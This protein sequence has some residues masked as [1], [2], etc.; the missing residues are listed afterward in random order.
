M[1]HLT[2]RITT[3]PAAQADAL[4]KLRILLR[5]AVDLGW[6]ASDPSNGLRPP[7]TRRRAAWSAGEI[8]AFEARWSTGTR[9]RLA[10]DLLRHA[11]LRGHQIVTTVNLDLAR[12]NIQPAEP[13]KLRRRRLS[14]DADPAMAFALT[15]ARGRPFSAAGLGKFMARAIADAELPAR[16]VADNLRPTH[17]QGSA[18]P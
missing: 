9:Q 4:K 15:T 16:C 2:A 8:A 7:D 5:F 18:V 13:I 1:K 3:G 10:F 11:G 17:A 6:C 12:W 14:I